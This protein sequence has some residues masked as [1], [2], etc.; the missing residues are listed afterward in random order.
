MRSELEWVWGFADV[1]RTPH[2]IVIRCNVVLPSPH[3]G[4]RA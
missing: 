3:K 1:N 2:P 4:E